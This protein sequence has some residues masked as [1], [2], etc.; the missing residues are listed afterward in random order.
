MKVIVFSDVH[1]EQNIIDRIIEWNPDSDYI[2]S[3]GDTELTEEYLMNH[4]IVMIKGNYRHD[5]GFVYERTL[6]IEGKMIF[7]THGH[8]HSVHR[9]TKKLA[10]LAIENDYDIVLYGHTHIVRIEKVG[11]VHILNPG[12]CARPR[13]MLPPTY[14][15]LDITKGGLTITIKDSISNRTIE[16]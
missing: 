11:K 5:P 7:M 2:L 6:E 12:S 9:G 10:K 15:I 4:D 16:V 14:M 3:L 13:N 8:K 1:G